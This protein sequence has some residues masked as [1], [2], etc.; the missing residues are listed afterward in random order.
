MVA[1]RRSLVT[2][3]FICLVAAS[4]AFGSAT[5]IS[6]TQSGNPSGNCTTNVQTPAFFNNGGNWGSAANQIGP[7]TTVLIC[8]TFTGGGGA[9]E[10]T[11][12]GSGTSASPVTL[13]FDTGAQLNAPYW[14]SNGAISCSNQQHIVV[15]GG[16]NGLI[17]N[18]ANG[19][20]LANRQTSTGFY[21]ANCTNSEVKNLT[22]RNIYVNQGS[23]SGASDTAGSNTT[24]IVFNGN[25]TNSI[26]DNN[27]VSQAKTGIQF[28]MDPN[29]DASNIQI[30]GNSV[31]DIDWGINVGGGDG[32]D[33]ATN[34]V[35]HD[36]SITN[37]TN[38]QF[39]TYAYHQ[40]GVILFNV[41][42]PGAG[43]IATL[44]NNHI[45]GDLGVGSP[46]GFIYC[47][48]FTS[49]TIYNNL[50][51]N[52]G[53]TID[54]ILWLG[55]TSNNG[56]SYSVYN[57]TIVSNQN[58]IAITLTNTGPDKIENNIAIGVNVAIHDYHNLTSDVTVSDHNV[59]RTASGN[60]PQMYTND[61]NPVSY[62]TWKADGFD[63][64]STNSD[65]S[66][67]GSYHLQ[68]GSSATGLATNLTDLNTNPLDF[69]MALNPR[70]NS[71]SVNWDAGVYNASGGGTAP[72]PP[73]NLA[74]VVQ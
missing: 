58:D 20:G 73:T 65:P 71:S 45:Y 66:L 69:D 57:N 4:P 10:F 67:D 49:C 54:G 34:V 62:S 70:P 50:L 60:A 16:T 55:Q 64:H 6:I 19:T 39:P 22:I 72:V 28:A 23:N 43:L 12:Q 18:T 5:N 27:T 30:Y 31:S 61:S 40:D 26:A 1:I 21:A 11:F 9:T 37:W 3:F 29:G 36:N 63:A 48:D 24:A 41:G 8:G 68:S 13:R 52:T 7:G 53:H 15:D 25:S 59:W 32:G 42:N 14:S 17:Q 44:Y 47:A 2:V 51:V 46:T 56:K 38:W 33:T 74:A 35:I